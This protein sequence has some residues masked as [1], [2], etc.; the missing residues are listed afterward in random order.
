METD[1]TTMD[2][3][4]D[5]ESSLFCIALACRLFVTAVEKKQFFQQLNKCDMA[6]QFTQSDSFSFAFCRMTIC[7][8]HCVL[9]K[10]IIFTH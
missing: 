3:S 10:K 1:A 4:R 5:L 6:V 8:H 2:A 9:L 7:K